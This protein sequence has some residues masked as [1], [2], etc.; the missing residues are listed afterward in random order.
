MYPHSQ[1]EQSYHGR[2]TPTP[3][4]RVPQPPTPGSKEEGEILTLDFVCRRPSR[5]L[6]N[7]TVVGSDAFTPYFHIMTGVDRQTFV[8]TNKGH[9]IA[10]IEWSGA[11]GVAYV[12]VHNSV[13]KQRVSEWLSVS[14]DAR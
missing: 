8:R 11:G 1:S 6:L 2:T 12:E 10:A 4:R 7:C 14:G 13:A 9:T 3:R 5:T